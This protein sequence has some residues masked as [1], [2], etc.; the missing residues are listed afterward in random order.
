MLVSVIMPVYN[1]ALLVEKSIA[2]V[3]AQT[4][5]DW[6]LI[7]VDDGST[8]N[9]WEILKR[10]SEQDVRVFACKREREPKNANTCRNIGAELSNGQFLM[11]L[12]SDDLLLE[13]TIE[14]RV[15]DVMDSN[16][17]FTLYDT[18]E[19]INDTVKEKHPKPSV[20]NKLIRKRFLI[21]LWPYPYNILSVF[22]KREVF[23][24]IGKFDEN[25]YRM[26]DTD[27]LLRLTDPQEKLSFKAFG[28]W[29]SLNRRHSSQGSSNVLFYKTFSDFICKYLNLLKEEEVP[30]FKHTI[31][32]FLDLII[33][34]H[35]PRILFNGTT[36]KA[37]LKII[38]SH[39]L[40]IAER[41]AFGM[42]LLVFFVIPFKPGYRLAHFFNDR[43]FKLS[44]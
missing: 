40:S 32:K 42:T 36:R 29:D 6:E 27:L 12:D 11:F 1:R 20:E 44:E 22:V 30:L 2:S 5:R 38:R 26:Q 34:V 43:Y 3:Q 39:R 33:S 16:Y 10:T 9:S 4:Y 14:N 15:R 41:L 17:D 19:L 13:T 28:R 7:L 8:D 24:R 23:F 25:L 31:N 21:G 18:A 35:R 37:C